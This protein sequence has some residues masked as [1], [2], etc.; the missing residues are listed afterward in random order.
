MGALLR[1]TLIDIICVVIRWVFAEINTEKFKLEK[2]ELWEIV[3]IIPPRYHAGDH[4]K[5]PNRVD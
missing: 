4:Q 1:C 2:F 3:G 5:G